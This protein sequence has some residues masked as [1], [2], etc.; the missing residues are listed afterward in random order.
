MLLPGSIKANAIDPDYSY[1]SFCLL[2]V[3]CRAAHHSLFGVRL[4]LLEAWLDPGGTDH[5]IYV[6]VLDA[7]V[8]EDGH[9]TPFYCRYLMARTGWPY[10]ALHSPALKCIAVK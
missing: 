4:L 3:W 7:A 10:V 5:T 2:T 9:L 8:Q 1:C 6:G